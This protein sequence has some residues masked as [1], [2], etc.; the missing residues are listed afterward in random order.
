MNYLGLFT[1][2]SV[3]T[4]TKTGFGAFLLIKDLNQPTE[5]LKPQIKI[6]KFEHTSSTKLELQ[7]VLWAMKEIHDKSCQTIVY[8][9]S[10]NMVNLLARRTKL[11]FNNF[12]SKNGKELN[13]AQ[14]YK[15][16]FKLTDELDCEFVKVKGHK[17][18]ISKNNID[19]IF[20]LVDRASRNA[21]RN[22]I[23]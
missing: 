8:T 7:T 1:D 21:L 18:S 17:K 22:N 16:F 12:L 4:Q 10:Q 2:G 3:N 14:L 5:I 15:D 13:N 9:D 19:R 23:N 20:S 11:E 6:K